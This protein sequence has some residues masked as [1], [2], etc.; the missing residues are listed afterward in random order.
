MTA[1]TMLTFRNDEVFKHG[2]RERD[3]QSLTVKHAKFLIRS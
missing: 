2:K 3:Y 1:A